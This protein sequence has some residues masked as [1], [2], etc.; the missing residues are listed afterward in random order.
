MMMGYCMNIFNNDDDDD[1]DGNDGNVNDKSF[2]SLI[3]Y[4]HLH[5]RPV[6][7]NKNRFEKEKKKS[8]KVF[9][10]NKKCKIDLSG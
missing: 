10:E 6:K 9:R 7:T 4:F 5:C 3:P 8:I 1:D 2:I